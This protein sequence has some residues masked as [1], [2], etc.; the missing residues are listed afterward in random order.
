VE[1]WGAV[2]SRWPR[3]AAAATNLIANG[4]FEGSGAGSLTGWGA[5]N[6]TLAIVAGSGGGQ[7]ARVR[8]ASAAQVYAYTTTKP[9]KSTVKGTAYR[10]DAVVR[11]DTP[12]QSVCLKVKEL[13]AGSSTAVGSARGPGTTPRSGSPTWRPAATARARRPTLVSRSRDST[14]RR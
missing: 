12:G 6:G 8:P 10:L 11:S 4:T 7:A 2:E 5:S 3:P 1:S 13:P 14:L 9:V